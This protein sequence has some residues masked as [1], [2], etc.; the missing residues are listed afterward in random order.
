MGSPAAESVELVGKKR[1]KRREVGNV[2]FVVV[3]VVF[4]VIAYKSR[5]DHSSR[6][7]VDLCGSVKTPLHVERVS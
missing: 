5:P 4:V 3:V 2:F 7:A 6:Y 1:R